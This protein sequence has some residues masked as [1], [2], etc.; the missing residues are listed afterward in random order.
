ML[1]VLV[2][3]LLLATVGLAGTR[4]GVD[5]RDGQDWQSCALLSARFDRGRDAR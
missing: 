2:V 3:I 1:T 4:W 5:S